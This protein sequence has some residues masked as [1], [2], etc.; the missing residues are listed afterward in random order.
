MSERATL[1]K[2]NSLDPAEVAVVSNPAAGNDASVVLLRRIVKLL[3]SSAVVDAN[4]RQRV[5]VDNV[6][7][8]S[9]SATLGAPGV[10]NVTA[11]A[12]TFT[13][14]SY[15]PVWVGPVDQRYLLMDQ[16]RNTYANS[17]RSQLIF[18]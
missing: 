5:A 17:V 3:E 18:S 6:L 11:N 8:G 13:N 1:L 12:P 7:L 2:S 4:M 16:A 14:I 9:G 15:V 10:N